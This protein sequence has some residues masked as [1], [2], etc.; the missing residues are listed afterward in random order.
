MKN[1]KAGE[2]PGM[3]EKSK[4]VKL[5]EHYVSIKDDI[6]GLKEELEEISKDIV[7]ALEESGDSAVVIRLNDGAIYRFELIASEIKLH[8]KREKING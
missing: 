2:L 8:V 1:L 4:A 5:A 7:V 3:P 6:E